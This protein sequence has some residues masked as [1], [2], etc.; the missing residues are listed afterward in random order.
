M[1]KVLQPCKQRKSIPKIFGFD[2][3]TYSKKNI[4]YCCSL[5]GDGYQKTFDRKEDFV[6]EI[7][8]KRFR[9]SWIVATNL[10][11]DFFCMYFDLK[12]IIEMKMI[13][14]GSNMIFAQK[15]IKKGSGKTPLKFIGTENFMKG[16]VEKLGSF[17]GVEKMTP[18][19]FGEKPKTQED[20]DYLKKYNMR[21]SEISQKVTK[22]LL[23]S[24]HDL[25]ASPKVTIAS[26]ALSLF[27]NKYLKQKF[28]I[29]EK[30]VLRKILNAYYGG[31]TEVFQRGKV[32]D[33]YYY[34]VNSLYPSCMLN[35]FPDPNSLHLTKNSSIEL[36]NKF[37]GVSDIVIK[38]PL[39]MN[40]PFLPHR[41]PD[42]LWFPVGCLR[43]WYSHLEI[44]EALKLG[45]ELVEIKET[46]YY[47]KTC[48]PF[49]DYVTDLYA[50]RLKY[51]KEKSNMADVV[52]LLLTNLYGKF[53]Q[54]FDEKEISYHKDSDVNFSKYDRIEPVG[55]FVR[56]I[57]KDGEP[58]N[59]CIP[60]WSIYVTAYGRIKLYNYLKQYDPIYC[61]TDSLVTRFKIPVSDKLGE[62][63]LEDEIVE[64]IF[65]KPKMYSYI[66]K[67]NKSHFKLK[68]VP[69]KGKIVYDL[70]DFFGQKFEYEK[71]MKF[72]EALRRDLTPNEIITC[73]KEISFEDTKRVWDK[74][75][76]FD[77]LQRS[78]PH[79]IS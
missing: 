44:I 57:T 21:D 12:D 69:Q 15:M 56:C 33:V 40:I 77:E 72:K 6:A 59:F 4:F 20:I 7:Q 63:K 36:I 39:D 22:F 50:K 18:P 73:F 2:C 74:K 25:G 52:K 3:E 76:S 65:V 19:I 13:N 28:Y 8:K 23:Q 71:F 29:H 55:D 27:K 14:R 49:N 30:E 34:D 60:I 58:S 43:G 38:C 54:K 16:S 10:S 46:I 79:I 37:M 32:N 61:D 42:K 1:T 66:G 35:V 64:G 53:G 31:R 5:Y 67:D 70:H 26:T 68:G 62:M 11:F 24:F 45:Y 78:K 75:F 47:T 51:Q 17:I 41:E 48:S 9:N